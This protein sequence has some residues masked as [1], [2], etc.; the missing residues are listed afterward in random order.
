VEKLAGHPG[1]LGIVARMDETDP[2]TPP[3][4][5]GYRLGERLGSG[6]TGT[7]WS[8]LRLRDLLP[9]AV[10][11]VP[12]GAPDA[13]AD[14]AGSHAA[15]ELAVLGRVAVEGL[16]GF[17][18][19]LGLN[20]DPPSVALVLDYVAGGSLWSAVRA[21]GHLSVGESVTVLVPV[22]RALSGL[23][24]IG[25]VHG[26]VSPR[27]VLLQRSGQ[28]VLSDLG[29]ARVT[30]V[31]AA[32]TYG[33]TGF[34]APELEGGSPPTAASDVYAV[35]ALGCWCVT[36]EV[37]TP[38]A[39]R[40][41][42]DK[43][44]PGLPESWRAV[45]AQALSRDPAERPTAEELALAYFDS[46]PCEPLRLVVGAD[47]TSLLTHRLRRTASPE[48]DSR[49]AHT[50]RHGR[51]RPARLLRTRW[52]VAGAATLTAVGLTVCG[53]AFAGRLPWRGHSAR[54]AIQPRVDSSTGLPS[55]NASTMLPVVTAPAAPLLRTPGTS[56]ATPRDLATDRAAV[57]RD[58]RDLMQALADLRARVMTN[59]APADLAALD[60]FGS[61]A[62]RGDQATLAD[63]AADHRTYRDVV[64]RVRTARCVDWTT[65]TARV[66][67]TVDTTAYT[68]VDA[69][70]VAR[71]ES[72]PPA[73][74][75]RFTLRWQDGRWRIEQVRAL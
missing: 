15:R 68:V 26:D 65:T 11:V 14:E 58:P 7:V 61:A 37:P 22:A 29:V 43:V 6:A 16:V 73:Q 32:Q 10:K 30:G 62:L 1:D 40:Q 34:V 66:D 19:A 28:P 71:H 47:D 60:V 36:G 27:N 5:P 24:A 54:V 67:A 33:T 59:G 75:L 57:R 49:P 42:L 64:L 50:G 72:L 25:V 51:G 45:T 70:G 8:A 63:L 18:E 56:T 20:T 23:H 2:M 9:V 31:A 17:H 21:R 53:V 4:V 74:P 35:G 52:L 41:P 48:V 38:G 39:L 12:V 3:E 69:T 55:V 13:P 46:A 44:A